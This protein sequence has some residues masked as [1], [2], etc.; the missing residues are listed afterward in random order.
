MTTK[1]GHTA[2]NVGLSHLSYYVPPGMMTIEE[3][4]AVRGFSAEQIGH[5][6]DVQG[7]KLF[8]IAEEERAADLALKAAKKIM[9]QNNID[10]LMIDAVV[11]YNTT[12]FTTLEPTSLVGKIQQELGLRRSIGFAIWGQYCVSIISALRVARNMINAG[13]ARVVLLIGTDCYFGSYQREIAGITLQ[14]EGASAIILNKNCEANRLLALLTYTE[15][16]LYKGVCGSEEDYVKFDLI[17]FLTITRVIHKT[18]KLANLTLDDIS[19]ILPHNINVAGWK[20]ILQLLKFDEKKFFGENIVRHGHLFGSDLIVN[21]SDAVE[22]GRIKKG[23]YG[24]L[25]TAGM[26]ATWGCAVVQH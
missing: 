23:E 2:S 16:S 15:G 18:L 19:L 8:H 10:P 9:E 3:L 7:I 5:Y 1:D 17:Y 20:R 6:R 26:G 24:L 14:G 13:S 11:L 25:V 22:A 21:L 4:G 12:Y